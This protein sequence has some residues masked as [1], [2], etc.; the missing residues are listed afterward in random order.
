MS[1]DPPSDVAGSDNPQNRQRTVI[2]VHGQ[3]VKPAHKELEDAWTRA[4]THGLQRDHQR[5][6]EGL[7]VEMVYYGEFTGE[8]DP[9][10]ESYDESLDL[11]DRQNA[12]RALAKL[13]SA[14]LFRRSSYEALP[15]QSPIKEF[16]ADIGVPLVRI[17]GFGQKRLAR[18]MPELI[19]YW[20]KP[21]QAKLLRQRFLAPLNTALNRGDHVLV[22]S[23]C[24]GSV[25]CYDA[26][27]EASQA[28]AT[29]RRV[30][31]WIT[32]GSPLADDDVKKNL[33][34]HPDNYPNMLINWFNVA[35]E[36]DPYCH[37]ET[38]ANDFRGMLAS[39]QISR[40][41]DYHI[42]NLTERYGKSDPHGAVG[43]LIHPRTSQLIADWF[44]AIPDT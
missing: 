21:D 3:G 8:H 15:G 41:Q 35:A 20:K 12:F 42:Y 7:N 26:F 9:E 32:L 33:L 6:L 1:T 28:A 27:F 39:R 19:H 22:I 24:T 23:H 37:D 29:D 11:A 38:V 34:G 40:I 2:L 17:L 14:K 36:D 4:L 18:Y 10:A 5:S 25:V 13:K 44:T 43:Y 16:I 30:H 31:S